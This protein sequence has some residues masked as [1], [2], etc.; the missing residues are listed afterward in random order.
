[1]ASALI[2]ELQKE[3]VVSDETKSKIAGLYCS[4]YYMK[5]LRSVN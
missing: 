1:M 5:M 2:A 4:Q 3:F